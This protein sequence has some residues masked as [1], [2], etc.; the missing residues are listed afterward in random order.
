MLHLCG[1]WQGSQALVNLGKQVLKLRP[2]DGCVITQLIQGPGCFT[3]D[4]RPHQPPKP[5]CTVLAA[6]KTH[7]PSGESGQAD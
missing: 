5:F 4:L 3:V 2:C 6:E 7:H 1:C